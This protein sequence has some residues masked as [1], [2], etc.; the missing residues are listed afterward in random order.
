M[1]EQ[2]QF[3]RLLKNISCVRIGAT[4]AATAAMVLLTACGSSNRSYSI[5]PRG[6][7]FSGV[8]IGGQQHI[9]GAAIQLYAVNTTGDGAP[10]IPLLTKPILTDASGGFSINEAYSCPSSSSQVY[11]VSSGGNPGIAPGANNPNATLMA[12]LGPCGDISSSTKVVM[13]EI[14]TVA[15]A[16]A[17]SSFMKSYIDV[18]S[19]AS[20]A[21]LL[22][23]SVT[24][25][26]ELANFVA[27]TAP[28][29]ALAAD[30]TAPVQKLITLANILA[31]CINSVGGTAGDSS[32]CGSLFSD[33]S[34]EGA[35]AP[36]N[37]I[38]AALGIAKNPSQNVL[39]IFELSESFV[40]FPGSL[41]SVPDDWT[42]P[43]TSLVPP[44]TFIPAPGTYSAKQLVTLSEAAAGTKIY[45]TTDG[46]SP[47]TSS[48]LYSEPIQVSA[49][50]TIRAVAF[51]GGASSLLALGAY[52]ISPVTV[53]VTPASVSLSSSQTQPFEATVQGSPN[54]AVNWSLSPAVGTISSAGLYVAPA[55]VVSS[56]VVTVVAT[57]V[58]DPTKTA[59]ASV[60]V[61]SALG[62]AI[63]PGNVTL[64]LGHSQTFTATV[65][66]SSN[67]AVNWS[68]S[69]AVG[70]ISSAGLY[71]APA[72]G[73]DSEVVT[74]VATSVADPTKTANASIAL[75]G[76]SGPAYYVSNDGSDSNDGKSMS[77][78]WQTIAKVNATTFSPGDSIL[79]QDGGVW[80]EQLT[81]NSSGTSTSP[82]TISSYG[83]GVQPIIDGADSVTEWTQGSGQTIPNNV[84]AA[85]LT[86]APSQIF[87]DGNRLSPVTSYLSM[88]LGSFFWS[89]NT[90]YVRLAGDASPTGHTIL[91]SQRDFNVSLSGTSYI[92]VTGLNLTRANVDNLRIDGAATGI[93]LESN[94]MS[95]AYD[96][97]A[98]V[99]YPG[100]GTLVKQDISIIGNTVTEC[101]ADGVFVGDYSNNITIAQNDI[102]HVAV[103]DSDSTGSYAY[104]LYTGGI[105]LI[106]SP[107]HLHDVTVN[108]NMVYMNGTAV[109]GGGVHGNGIWDD[110]GG[111]NI[112]IT[113][114]LTYDNVYYGIQ[115]E[116]TNGA[117]AQA[118][119]SY[120][121]LS[122]IVV[123]ASTTDSNVSQNNLVY[124]NTV[125]GNADVGI[126]VSGNYTTAPQPDSSLK[127]QVVNNISVKNGNRNIS[128]IFGGENDGKYGSGNVYQYNDF[129]VAA[130]D[131]IEWGNS[132]YYSTYSAWETAQGSCSVTGCSH[133]VEAD[134]KLANP[135]G[136]NLTLQ[137]DSPAIGTGINLG[138]SYDL[139]IRPSATWPDVVTGTQTP[140]WNI[141]A[142]L[143]Q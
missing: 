112:S 102:S 13:N 80:R 113:N 70:T 78:P 12:L 106:G 135:A 104:H 131:F 88:P 124:N 10:A 24:T 90:V 39:P 107:A 22:D 133:S 114:N 77:A 45:Y 43:I 51:V 125:Y 115:L 143:T 27:G 93:I 47:S 58:A 84:Y 126:R 35:S 128:A 137:I 117:V 120:G 29:P 91:A 85:S 108:R 92:S 105:H 2:V 67:T 14:T 64:T 44:P 49:S 61:N 122:G 110:T 5:V 69:P 79:F 130:N 25:G 121:N 132:N 4:L 34:S 97:C 142:Y 73:V 11:I 23:D 17:L 141:G 86:T 99:R 42:L 21:P 75:I 72:S 116:N 50:T 76:S 103:I 7:V 28:G 140:E 63:T 119:V 96:I 66:N 109:S 82:I 31:A 18:G 74:V 8:T 33:A 46:S 52:S 57:S 38:D 37:T 53:S 36:T 9:A 139:A 98:D 20:D 3:L 68:L 41:T 136:G 60:Q 118:N 1:L 123:S 32:P 54:T 15:S 111:A 48:S 19:S 30:Q 89:S 101:G 127:N 26:N 100:S 87:V 138:T 59:S 6:A 16:Y 83:S 134:P 94:S 129:G 81:L 55:S 71:I 62:V 95:S 65:V 40:V 56:E